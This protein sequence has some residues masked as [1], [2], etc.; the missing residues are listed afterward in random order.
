LYERVLSEFA[1]VKSGRGSTLGELA[2]TYSKLRIGKT[3]PDITSE[4]VAGDKVRLTDYRGKVV[5]LDIWATWCGPCRAMIP[6]EREMVEK[7]KNK[8]F[9]LVSISFDQNKDDLKKFLAKEAMPWT[10][11]WNGQQGGIAKDWNIRHF[12]TIYVLDAKGVIRYK[13]VR[14]KQ[15]EEAVEK[16][17]AEVEDKR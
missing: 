10:H 9:A 16:L 7:L 3:A 17:L 1:D 4:D 11:W 13:E 15:L 6:H 8:P 2:K 12:P 5:V 14:G